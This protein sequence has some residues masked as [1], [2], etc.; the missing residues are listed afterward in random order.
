MML[1]DVLAVPESPAGTRRSELERWYERGTPTGWSRFPRLEAKLARIRRLGGEQ[2]AA[3]AGALDLEL[4][5]AAPGAALV[6][7]T[8]SVF[9]SRR[10]GCQTYQPLYYGV[11]IAALCLKA[12]QRTAR[13]RRMPSSTA[14]TAVT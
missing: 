12:N 7:E 5:R 4:A 8:S 11:D 14:A 3:A 10:V 2:R 9:Y 6:T 1:E 13:L